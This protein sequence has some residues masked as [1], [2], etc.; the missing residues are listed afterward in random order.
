MAEGTG[1]AVGAIG[2]AGLFS[3]CVDCFKLVQVYGARSRDY[4]TL[5]TMLDN[6]QFHFMAW[7]RACGFMDPDGRKY[8]FDGSSSADINK[9]IRQTMERIIALFMD[10]ESL[11]RKYGLKAQQ[12]TT[13][14]AAVEG[15]P[16]SA[17]SKVFQ[18]TKDFWNTSLQRKTQIVGT[19][20]WAVSDRDKF[21]ALIKNLRDL[22]SDLKELT[23]TTAVPQFQQ[24]I[25]KYELEMIDDQSS[26]EIITASA[27]NEDDDI[28]STVAGHRLA[29]VK[30]Q[31]IAN[32]SI[33]FDDSASMA[34]FASHASSMS[35]FNDENMAGAAQEI[36]VM[37]V[38]I[39]E[40]RNVKTH[41][42]IISWLKT[43]VVAT[44]S[45]H[46]MSELTD[47]MQPLSRVN[48]PDETGL[49]TNTKPSRVAINSPSL[50]NSL[51]KVTKYR[52]SS[53]HNVLVHPFKPLIVYENELRQ[54]T[55]NLHE[56]LRRL[57]KRH[58]EEPAEADDSSEPACGT[59]SKIQENRALDIEKTRRAI[60]EL[61]C[62]LEFMDNDLTELL[63]IRKQL[64]AQSLQ[65]I[66]FEN[67]WLLFRPGTIAISPDPTSDDNDTAY[68]ILHVTGGRRILDLD[69]N[70]RSEEL[71]NA[72][73]FIHNSQHGY[74]V[75][76]SQECTDFVIDCFYMDFDGT[77]YGPR[78]QRFVISEYSAER[79]ALSLPLY[80][81]G[82][83][84]SPTE[85]RRKLLDRGERFLEC[86]RKGWYSYYNKALNEWDPHHRDECTVCARDSAKQQ[87]SKYFN[88]S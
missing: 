35:T 66:S 58:C 78:S 60:Q 79:D 64:H 44:G 34:S 56:N 76:S 54:Y 30:A 83:S 74:A 85:M 25:T 49:T 61:E 73:E 81:I 3:T 28:L 22:I 53:R 17:F 18:T 4:E 27:D 33:K 42:G 55:S 87:V 21:E 16:V 39:S 82:L 9:Q 19:N 12:G 31:S 23:E 48:T 84:S 72:G 86:T 10:S 80:P 50:I 67:L 71:D 13:Q 68:Q 11:R 69:N 6:Q 2:L 32:R 15:P 5:Q 41:A 43:I 75:M 8:T 59:E 29:R 45:L 63:H 36:G 14:F 26:L 40:W 70:S 65:K 47:D 88:E 52:F 57:E 24:V 46:N 37:R 51:R 1:L 62:L 7:G 77:S 38:H 20:R